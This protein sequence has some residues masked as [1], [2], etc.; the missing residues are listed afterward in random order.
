V[1]QPGPAPKF[2]RTQAGVQGPPPSL[3]QDTKEGLTDWGFSDD[4]IGALLAS[5]AVVQMEPYKG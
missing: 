4:E 3:G 2:S 1:T 5:G